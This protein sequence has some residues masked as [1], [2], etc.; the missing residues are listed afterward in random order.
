MATDP[1][2]TLRTLFDAALAAVSPRLVLPPHLPQPPRGRTAV[3]G[4]G[5][6]A[7]EMARAFEAHW[8][9]PFEGFAVT[10]YGHA[11]RCRT[12]EVIEAGHPVPDAAAL[13]AADRALALAAGLGA[14][15]LLL[16]LASGGGSALLAKPAPGIALAEKQALTRSLLACGAAIGEINCVRKHLSAIKGGRLAAA[17][18]PAEVLTL[19]ISDV[20]GDDPATIA[21]GPTVADPTDASEARA[22]LARYGIETGEAAAAVLSGPAGE[23]PDRLANARFAIVARARDAL[24][25]AAREA[26]RQGIAARILGD[27]LAGEARALGAA[28]A[29]LARETAAGAGPVVLLSGGET[30]VTLPR[31]GFGRGGRNTEYL[32]AL[33]AGLD[34][35]PGIWAIA[36]DTDGID[37]TEDAAGA[38]LAPDSLARAADSGL[39]ARAALAAHDSYGYFAALGDLVVTGPTRTNVNDF[40]AILIGAGAGQPAPL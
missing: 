32:L 10:R 14:G 17:A 12:I 31:P 21:S 20:P 39:D 18:A 26:G 29:A 9:S 6:A 24:E 36:C 5:K 28:H 1:R 15:D 40:R 33:A 3:L 30:E 38:V 13:V 35:A 2:K 19:A 7:A 27:D 22:I 34:G 37:G 16:C 25:A 23:T 8:P 4:F 11:A